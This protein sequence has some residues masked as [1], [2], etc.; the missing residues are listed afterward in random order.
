MNVEEAFDLVK[1]QYDIQFDLKA[2][3]LE[4]VQMVVNKDSV[5]AILPTGFGKTMTYVV[6]PLIL[7][8]VSG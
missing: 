7:D 2:E 1:S 5:F 3:Q 8:Q 4:I 6:P